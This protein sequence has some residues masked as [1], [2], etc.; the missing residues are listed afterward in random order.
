M[1]GPKILAKLVAAGDEFPK[2]ISSLKKKKLRKV[3]RY[4]FEVH[5]EDHGLIRGLCISTLA[6]RDAY[7]GKGTRK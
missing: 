4:I 2:A 5:S 1:S 3:C 7:K 6:H